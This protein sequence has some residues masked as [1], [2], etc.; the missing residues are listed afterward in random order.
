MAQPHAG[1]TKHDIIHLKDVKKTY[2]TGEQATEI[3]HG[4]NLSIYP[5]EFTIIYGPSGSGKST[6]LNTIIGLEEIRE[7]T[8]TIRGSVISNQDEDTRARFR[9]RNIGVVYQSPFWVKTLNVLDNVALPL[10]IHDE[11][12]NAAKRKALEAL[13]HVGMEG[14]AKK[15]PMTLSGGQQQ[16]VNIARALVC[17]PA[18]IVADEPTGN[19]DSVSAN[20]II[21]LFLWFITNFHKSVIM[22]T[23]ELSF[24]RYAD[25]AV[26]IHDG[27]VE[28]VLTK[29]MLTGVVD[30]LARVPGGA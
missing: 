6:L 7:G 14:F 8:V 20:D 16:K 11:E 21:Q 15:S 25:R 19:L 24:L 5:Q 13:S 9:N 17:D 27:Y 23:H 29:D 3:L 4:I 12:G 10:L 30:N 2:G 28:S 1:K 18:I 22:V 26:S